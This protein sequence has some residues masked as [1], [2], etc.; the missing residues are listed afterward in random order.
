MDAPLSLG[1][2]PDG[3][4]QRTMVATEADID[5]VTELVAAAEAADDGVVEIDRE[6]IQADWARPAFDLATESVGVFEGDRLIAEAEVFKGRRGD[7]NVHPNARG[8]GI[9]TALLGWTEEVARSLGSPRI[10]QTVIDSNEAAADLFLRHGYVFGHTSWILQIENQGPPEVSLP[11]GFVFRRYGDADARAA[12]QVIEDA[13]NEWPN[14]DP[15]SFE[16]WAA[17]TIE[18][19]SFE[20]WQMLLVVDEVTEEL[21][22]VTFLI[23][24]VADGWIEQV[25]TKGTHRHRGIARGMLLQSFQAFWERGKPLVGLNTDSRT[26]A[27]GLYEKVGTR[28]TRSYTNRAKDL[29]EPRPGTH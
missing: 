9:G 20:P 15:A 28:V 10:A 3:L 7:V 18:R 13:F 4:T 29:T 8:R 27:L 11:A 6:D 22:G 21:V 23:D 1:G 24:Y 14:R 26:G 5:A 12:Y 2:L 17:L 25:A 19:A 16:D